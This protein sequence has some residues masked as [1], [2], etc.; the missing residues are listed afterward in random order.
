MKIAITVREYARLTTEAVAT[1]SLDR[2]QISVTA[3]DWLCQLSELFSKSG[4][5]LVHT[6]G[7][8][9][10]C[11]DNYVGVIETPC[12]TCIEI[13]PKH[14]EGENCARK[15][16]QLLCSMIGEAL[17]LPRREAG[18]ANLELFDAPLSEWVIAQFLEKLDHLVK[19]GVRFDYCRVEEEQR[20]LR[21]QLDIVRQL[22]QPPGRQHHF[23]IR[24]DLFLADRPENRLLKS[25]LE[26]VCASTRQPDSV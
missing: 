23:H 1:P 20:F 6:E 2:A 13:L 26:R 8:R 3:F 25:A 4:A 19:R 10:L 5:A 12:G 15:S 9:W 22:R 7:R 16:R 17:H 21:G 18:V 11:L 14:V 24:H